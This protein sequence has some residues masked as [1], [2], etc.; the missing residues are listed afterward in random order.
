M[1]KLFTKVKGHGYLKKTKLGLVSGIILASSLFVSLGSNTFVLAE[2]TNTNST[3]NVA[4]NGNNEKKDKFVREETVPV[5]EAELKAKVEEVKKSGVNVEEKPAESVGVAKTETEETT[6]KKKAETKVDEQIKDLEE[7]KKE[8]LARQEKAKKINSVREF[9]VSN[10]LMKHFLVHHLNSREFD[11]DFNKTVEFS[12]FKSDKGDVH[13]VEGKRAIL[14]RPD[15]IVN[16][17]ITTVPT[18]VK[19]IL[20]KNNINLTPLQ[21]ERLNKLVDSYILKVKDGETISYNIKVN[22]ESYLR[23]TFGIDTIEVKRTYNFGLANNPEYFDVITD[24]MIERIYIFSDLSKSTNLKEANPNV[25]TE[26]FY[27]DSTGMPISLKDLY[28]KVINISVFN[29]Q[30]VIKSS[31][32]RDENM[33]APEQ[34]RIQNDTSDFQ[35]NSYEG[36]VTPEGRISQKFSYSFIDNVRGEIQNHYFS[37]KD[38]LKNVDYK[39]LMEPVSANYHLVTYKKLIDTGVVQQ[40]FV[41]EKGNEIAPTITS[42]KSDKGT[43]VTVATP[44]N[45]ITYNGQ[46][47]LLQTEK[48]PNSL[49]IEKGINPVT[50][51]YK[52]QVVTDKGTPERLEVPEYNGPISMKGDPLTLE[53][54]EYSGPISMKGDPLTLEV[55]EYN[56]PI[57]MKGDPLIFE[58]PEYNGPINQVGEPEVQPELPKLVLNNEQTN[59]QTKVQKPVETVNSSKQTL[60]KTGSSYNGVYYTISASILSLFGILSLNFKKKDMK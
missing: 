3:G 10:N 15:S 30:E 33:N 56:G 42:E 59:S 45:E 40:K 34:V 54:P 9:Y 7:A 41:D 27:K 19:T 47:Y 58:V 1:N 44:P 18:K 26:Y 57:S 2:E 24:K 52:L 46:T 22:D 21:E 16:S 4:S 28:A 23:K 53:V 12:D 35:L 37:K 11:E 25:I 32:I 49:V 13:F 17:P 50:F 48:I 31:D 8:E 14:R 6:L 39:K 5:K 55:P 51:S 29:G 38:V 36:K 43:T 20:Y 60:P